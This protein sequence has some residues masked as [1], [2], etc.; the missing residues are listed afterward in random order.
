MKTT[1][2]TKILSLALLAMNLTFFG[3]TTDDKDKEALGPTLS[4]EPSDQIVVAGTTATFAVTASGSGTLTYQWMRNNVNIEG[5]TSAA[6]TFAPSVN[7]DEAA[8]S[9]KVTDSKSSTTSHDA[10]LRILVNS[11]QITLS[12][13]NGGTLSTQNSGTSYLDLDT[14]NSYTINQGAA[15]S[16]EIDLVFAYDTS[17][18]NDS[19]ALYSPQYAKSSSATQFS[20]M[21]SWSSANSTDMKVVSVAD[22]STVKTNADIK[23]LYDGGIISSPSGR[24][25]LT[26]GKF[27]AVKSSGG[28]YVLIRIDNLT[29]S[30]TGSMTISGKGRSL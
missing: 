27:L 8:Y 29:A 13:Q 4:V 11:K 9:V 18:T 24:V 3:C 20:F 1:H 14:W 15:H 30:L 23:A 6:Y 5:A 19:A 7:D 28:L 16:N 26:A 2:R 17:A 12:A 22:W 21:Q 10:F 25:Y